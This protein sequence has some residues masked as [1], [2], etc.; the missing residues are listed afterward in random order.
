MMKVAT[1]FILFPAVAADSESVN[2]ARSNNP[3][4]RGG[5]VVRKQ[6]HRH[7]GHSLL[8]EFRQQRAHK[9]DLED[10]T[11]DDVAEVDDAGEQIVGP[12]KYVDPD[13]IHAKSHPAVFRTSRLSRGEM[14]KRAYEMETKLQQVEEGTLDLNEKTV[15]R[16]KKFVERYNELEKE[17]HLMNHPEEKEAE[18]GNTTSNGDAA[19]EKKT[20][21]SAYSSGKAEYEKAIEK[22]KENKEKEVPGEK[23]PKVVDAGEE[24][25]SEK[26]TSAGKKSE[27]VYGAD[28][29]KQLR[30]VDDDDEINQLD[31]PDEIESKGD[32]DEFVVSKGEKPSTV[33]IEDDDDI[34]PNFEGLAEGKLASK[35]AEKS[36]EPEEEIVDSEGASDAAQEDIPPNF[37]GL[38]SEEGS[39]EPEETVAT[40]GNDEIPAEI[41]ENS[42]EKV[43]K[44]AEVVSNTEVPSKNVEEAIATQNVE[45]DDTEEAPL[46]DDRNASTPHLEE[47][48]ADGSED[49]GTEEMDKTLLP[50]PNEGLKSSEGDMDA[51][52]EER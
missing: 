14:E 11:A 39:E 3:N 13:D 27:Y 23:V 28:G 9:K 25:I 32:E 8:D 42:L 6:S 33:E 20:S 12:G 19:D 48:G 16:Y 37:E 40:R 50:K 4:L 18:E 15:D 10:D 51:D 45:T 52:G 21:T 36:P 31:T 7:E 41:V 34:P 2:Q 5:G 17:I 44:L 29:S 49:A 47:G 26:A 24:K 22:M 30:I 35:T 43:K 1:L 38:A 46:S